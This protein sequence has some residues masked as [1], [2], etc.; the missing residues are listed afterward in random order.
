MST[1]YKEH[2]KKW[3][4]TE[5]KVSEDMNSPLKEEIEIEGKKLRKEMQVKITW[6]TKL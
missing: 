6:A 4:N 3:E 2:L 1:V 5:K